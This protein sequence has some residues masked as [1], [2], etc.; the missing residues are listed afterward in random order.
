MLKTFL[1]HFSEKIGIDLG[2]ANTLVCIPEKG[3]VLNEPSV[4]AIETNKDKIS[5]ISVGEEAKLMIGRTPKKIQ[6]IRPMKDGVIADFEVAE[7][8]IAYFIKKAMKSKA[9]TGNSF[10]KGFIGPAVLVCVPYGST[11]VERRAIQEAAT[12]AGAREVFLIEEP[13]AAAVGAGLPVTD[14]TGSMVVDIGGGTTEIAVIS[15]G[16]IVHS[17]SI[18]VAGDKMD[19]DIMNYVKNKYNMFI[20]ESTAERVKKEVGCAMFDGEKPRSIKI[21]GRDMIGI[22]RQITLTEKDIAESL[23]DCVSSIVS[24]V[25]N[26]LS[27]IPP[28]LSSDISNNGMVLTGGGACLKNLDKYISKDTKLNVTIAEDP[29][30][31]V[32]MGTK[33]VL[34]QMDGMQGILLR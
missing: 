8:M 23:K 6:A 15:L 20:G 14:A 4:V 24:G 17:Q 27:N 19:E 9:M 25:K 2:T 10:L 18:K 21:S 12:V 30:L 29:L 11:L 3:V 13:M 22:P 1:H 7:K 16:G 5:V 31:C 28:E 33:K 34:E 26:V 32:V